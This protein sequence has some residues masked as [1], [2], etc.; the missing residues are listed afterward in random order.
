MSHN[1]LVSV[2]LPNY[3]HAPFLHRRI[4]S[5]LCQ[6]FQDFE[7][8]ILDDHST[9]GSTAIIQEYSKHQKV[10]KVVLNEQ[11]SGLTFHQWLKGIR[12][13]QGKYLWIAE[14]D[15]YANEHFLEKLVHIL[16]AQPNVGLAFTQSWLVNEND[17]ILF[18]CKRWSDDPRWKQD[19]MLDGKLALKAFAIY[20]TGMYNASA[21]LFR[22]EVFDKVSLA[23]TEFKYAGDTML[24]LE[25]LLHTDLFYV[26]EELNFFRTHPQQHSSN[27]TEIQ[28]LEGFENILNLISLNNP[29]LK[30]PVTQQ[31]IKYLIVKALYAYLNRKIRLLSLLKVMI[32]AARTDLL[33]STRMFFRYT[34]KCFRPT[35]AI[36]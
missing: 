9:D 3:N 7:L 6:T 5:I 11:N 26:A 21:V 14:S 18:S 17:E 33:C 24:W 16:E 35:F 8:I 25:M 27:T 20:T 34:G 4:E 31:K 32:A 30:E 13:A 10:T 28:L 2:I 29:L 12:L 1:P 23:F 22:K 19:F 15:D 36:I